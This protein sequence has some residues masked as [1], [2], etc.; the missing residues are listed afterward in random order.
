VTKFLLP[1]LIIAVLTLTAC[2]VNPVTGENQFSLISAAQ[3]VQIG[4]QNY[5][6]SQQQQGGEYVVDPKLS[7]YVSKVGHRLAALSDRQQLP[8]EFVVL[9]NDVPNAWALPGGKIAVNRGL[10]V[11]LD[12]EAQ[13]AAVLGHEIV[14]AA[15]RHGASQQT[16]QTLLGLGVAVVGIAS[17]KHEHGELIGMGTMVGASAWQARY[18]RGQELEADDYGINYMVAAGYDPQAAVELQQTF[19]KLSQGQKS[20]LLSSLFASHPPSAERVAK[21]REK[22]ASLPRGIRNRA[23]YQKAIAQL[24]KDAPAYA[25]HREALAAAAKKDIAVALHAVDQAIALQP[26]EASFFVTKGQLLLARKQ[27]AEAQ[28]VFKQAFQL[29]P[30]F[31]MTSLG[32]GLSEKMTGNSESAATNLEKSLKLLPTQIGAFHLGEIELERGNRRQA[33][34]YF[35]WAAQGGGELGNAALAHLEKLVPAATIPAQ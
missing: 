7:A 24:K 16:H 2:S 17:T 25:K 9:N 26:L 13:L 14:H 32:L 19:L 8:Y 23:A 34:E 18:G 11:L 29:N 1:C 28:A 22:A 35:K 33:V 3:E 30:T 27:D 20:D 15:A 21:N 31:Y 6:P 4:E 5:L 10:L 12:D